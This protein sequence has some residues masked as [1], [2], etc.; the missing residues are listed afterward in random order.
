MS[1]IKRTHKIG[2]PQAESDQLNEFR[3]MVNTD[4]LEAIL[5]EEEFA[6]KAYFSLKGFAGILSIPGIFDKTSVQVD[7]ETGLSVV[8]SAPSLRCAESSFTF[9]MPEKGDYV[10]IKGTV[11]VIVTSEPDGAGIVNLTL[12]KK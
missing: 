11:Y 8:S 12:Q 9:R 3:K 10:T 6:I 7:P 4:I 2:N 1:G 5:S